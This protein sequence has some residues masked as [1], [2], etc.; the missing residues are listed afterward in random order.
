MAIRYVYFVC[1]VVQCLI[2]F[3]V[4]SASV[5]TVVTVHILHRNCSIITWPFFCV[6]PTIMEFYLLF[7]RDMKP[8]L[9]TQR[10]T[11]S[12]TTRCY[13][14]WQKL[15]WSYSLKEIMIVLADLMKIEILL[16]LKVNKH[17][18]RNKGMNKKWQMELR[19]CWSCHSF[20]RAVWP[21]V[22]KCNVYQWCNVG[23][24]VLRTL[25]TVGQCVLGSKRAVYILYTSVAVMWKIH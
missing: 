13:L 15:I 12:F 21:T 25:K 9:L 17:R 22:N 24:P 7:L 19:N 2:Y 5:S 1:F 18:N 23:L 11:L 8:S 14:C 4:V 6:Y 3:R 16:Q 10:S 20:I